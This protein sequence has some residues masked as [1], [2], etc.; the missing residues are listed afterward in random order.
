MP[1]KPD[2]PSITGF[3]CCPTFKVLSK[4]S[5]ITVQGCREKQSGWIYPITPARTCVFGS[6]SSDRVKMAQT[7]TTSS[8]D[9]RLPFTGQIRAHLEWVA[10][11]RLAEHGDIISPNS[12]KQAHQQ[13]SGIHGKYHNNMCRTIGRL[14]SIHGLLPLLI[15]QHIHRWMDAQD[16]FWYNNKTST[17]ILLPTYC[18]YHDEVQHHHLFPTPKGETQ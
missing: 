16:K 13:R 1:S 11:L 18:K 5:I 17:R 8:S 10:I 14:H 4:L 15:R 9:P 6:N 2:R 3:L 7:S 12:T